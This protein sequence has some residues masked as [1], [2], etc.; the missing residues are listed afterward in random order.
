MTFVALK[1]HR[2]KEITMSSTKASTGQKHTQ[3]KQKRGRLETL[4]ALFSSKR[5]KPASS[6][7]DP[8]E[9]PYRGWKFHG[10][11]KWSH[12]DDEEQEATVNDSTDPLNTRQYKITIRHTDGTQY[13]FEFR[14]NTLEESSPFFRAARS[15]LWT[16]SETPT[17]LD[18]DVNIFRL[19]MLAMSRKRAFQGTIDYAVVLSHGH[20][21]ADGDVSLKVGQHRIQAFEYLIGTYLLAD[22][23]GDI[24]TANFVIDQIT[25]FSKEANLTPQVGAINQAYDSTLESN[26]LRM[27]LRDIFIH[28]A[29]ANAVEQACSTRWCKSRIPGGFGSRE[30]QAEV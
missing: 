22:Q 30:L 7:E 1:L 24:Q 27:L 21:T 23:F 11:G 17:V 14:G 5:S 25:R 13:E 16:D 15:G 28:Q 3:T 10:L 18:D 9:N 2:N 26:P 19:Y 20:P 6:D 8:K 12:V 4:G 29:S